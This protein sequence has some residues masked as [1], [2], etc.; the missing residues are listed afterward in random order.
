MLEEKHSPLLNGTVDVAPAHSRSNSHAHASAQSTIALSATP[1]SLADRETWNALRSPP[2]LQLFEAIRSC[3]GVDARALAEAL[4]ANAPRLYYH[5]N[6]LMKGGLVV[7]EARSERTLSRGPDARTYRAVFA[8]F[9]AGF[10]DGSV[11]AIKR[12]KALL[13]ALSTHGVQVAIEAM[14]P[15]GGRD[16]G[17]DGGRNGGRA[18]MFRL[19]V[20]DEADVAAIHARMQEIA[21]IVESARDRRVGRNAPRCATHF[22]S[23]CLCTTTAP[24]LPDMPLDHQ[25]I[26]R[27]T[28]A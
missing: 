26:S 15:E 12:C 17:R 2:R 3:P 18:P 23:C 28:L 25:P 19:E 4:G 27:K 10:F 14:A 9:P 16:G 7:A 20:L 5:L 1:L 21:H 8:E 11:L 22:V 13:N 24:A 6:V